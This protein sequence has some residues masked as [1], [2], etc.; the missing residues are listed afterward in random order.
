M[1]TNMDGEMEVKGGQLSEKIAYWCILLLTFLLPL[2]FVPSLVFP[3]LNG[4]MILFAGLV[5]LAGV[6]VTI[7]AW[8]KGEAITSTAFVLLAAGAVMLA[9][10][11]ATLFSPLRTLSF[12]G[13]GFESDTFFALLLCFLALKVCFVVLR[14]KRRLFSFY[15]AFL[16]SFLL[17][18]LF[19]VLR[20]A[21][22][23]AFLSFGVFASPVSNFIGKWNELGIFAG[24]GAVL[25]LGTLLFLNSSKLLKVLLSFMLIV[26]LAIVFVVNF[27]MVWI[28]LAVASLLIAFFAYRADLASR[29]KMLILPLIVFTIAVLAAPGQNR[30]IVALSN[31]LS[32][33]QLDVRPSLSGT[34]AIAQNELKAH[35]FFGTGPNRFDSAWQQFRPQE[36]NTTLF[37]NAHFDFAFGTLPT[38]LVTTGIIGALAWLLFIIGFLI[39]GVQA[40]FAKTE[41][42]LLRYFLPTSFL[43][44]LYLWVFMA[45]YAPTTV[46]LALTFLWTGAFFA[47]LAIDGRIRVKTIDLA[48]RPVLRPFVL[49]AVAFVVLSSAGILYGYGARFAAAYYFQKA[50][51][52]LSQ[53]SDLKSGTAYLDKAASLNKFDLYYRALVEAD[54]IALNQ[55]FSNQKELSQEAFAAQSNQLLGKTLQDATAA[56][57]LNPT[58]FENW[59]TLGRTYSLVVP[60]KIDGLKAYENAKAAFTQALALA[61]HNPYLQLAFAELE[62]RNGNQKASDDYV[63]KALKEK[64]DYRDA[65]F[66]VVQGQ[67]AAKDTKGAKE[68]LGFAAQVLPNDQ[69]VFYN[70][71]L[72]RYNDGEYKSAVEALSRAIQINPN[73]SN[74]L[75]YIGLALDKQGDKKDAIAVFQRI[76]E[77]NP[78]SEEIKA[79]LKNLNAGKAALSGIAAGTPT[80]ASNL[81]NTA[82]Q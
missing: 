37:W 36:I 50:N 59:V 13:A 74:A 15:L 62:Y 73:Y 55:L 16:A 43:A 32:I 18:G 12:F 30:F 31:R 28:T 60:L 61:P 17:I 77:L 48:S 38:A 47:A 39:K 14:D 23:P 22:G 25:S 40:L 81:G 51:V 35:P 20:L 44:A 26:A 79:I 11:L 2:F 21:F 63:A 69:E 27:Q 70:L 46:V 67:L 8:R 65:F 49:A 1:E 80:P 53:N 3:L 34:S 45:T 76:L 54:L 6:C 10:L 29:K 58:N 68:T 75:Y 64:P 66:F 41:D 24:L 82:A 19:H 33:S 42:P 9:T 52:A 5:L 4:K 57:T 72:I 56:E 7:S 71:G 78:Q